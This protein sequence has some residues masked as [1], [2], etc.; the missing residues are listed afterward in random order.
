MKMCQVTQHKLEVGEIRG[1]TGDVPDETWVPVS[2]GMYE[3]AHKLAD[4]GRLIEAIQ[5]ATIIRMENYGE[6]E[7]L[8]FRVV[9]TIITRLQ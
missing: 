2:A 3:P 7:G 4:Q 5:A 8:K 6:M 9:T 1:Y